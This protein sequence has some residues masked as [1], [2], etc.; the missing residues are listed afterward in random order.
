VALIVEIAAPLSGDVFAA[1][2]GDRTAIVWS[3][4]NRALVARLEI[5][6]DFGGRRA[7][8]VGE[9]LVVGQ[10]TRTGK[11]LSGVRA[12]DFSGELAWERAD[13]KQPQYLNALPR[14]QLAVGVE[15]S[16]LQVLD[17]NGDTVARVRGAD[18]IYGSEATEAVLVE[19]TSGWIAL[20]EEAPPGKRMWRRRIE[21]FAVLDAALGA[22]EVAITEAGGKVT[23]FG[24]DGEPRWSW[25]P[26]DGEHVMRI[27]WALE[28]NC[29]PGLLLPY[30]H[31]E[32]CV[33][34]TLDATG[35]LLSARNVGKLSAASF[36]GRGEFL[37][38]ARNSGGEVLRVRD[39]EKVWSFEP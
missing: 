6:H 8:L 2:Y 22:H 14:G 7:A 15:Y 1:I 29:W 39:G 37:V 4:S 32:S 33:L 10:Y 19:G 21:S 23:A 18:S 24:F 3:L 36:V 28:A 16:S 31:A 27:G 17:D 35:E 25:S 5:A 11:N 9:R 12:Y 38:V 13:L 30:E 26:P 34:V 20:H